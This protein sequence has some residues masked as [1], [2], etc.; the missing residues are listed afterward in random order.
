[1][2][3]AAR[4]A[5]IAV[6][7]FA[8]HFATYFIPSLRDATFASAPGLAVAVA[9][10]ALAQHAVVFPVAANLPAP[11]LARLAAYVWLIGDMVSDLMQLGGLPTSNYLALRLTVNVLAAVWIGAASWQAPRAMLIVGAIVAFDLVAYSLSATINPA[12]FVI[13]LPSLVL[14]P[15]WF[16]L[17]GRRLTA[18]AETPPMPSA[19]AAARQ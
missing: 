5:Y 10:L 15:I 16:V 7:L 11:R 14:V 6:V 3:V 4:F 8:A 19:T 18:L 9:A 1:M 12:A 2:R 13:S 17:V